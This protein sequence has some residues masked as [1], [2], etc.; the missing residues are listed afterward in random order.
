M[1]KKKYSKKKYS[2]NE[3]Y[4]YHRNRYVAFVDK[5]RKNAE[6]GTTIDFDKLEVAEKKNPKMQ[7]SEGYSEFCGNIK[8][9]YVKSDED[10]KKKSKS[11]QAGH[12]AAKKAYEKSRNIKF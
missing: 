10:L 11:Y 7:Y 8:R 12:A 2:Y 3:R 4:D 6:Y 1:A 9:G 5:F